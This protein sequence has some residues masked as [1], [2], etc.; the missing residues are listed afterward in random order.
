MEL[1]PGRDVVWVEGTI[2]SVE[3]AGS[4]LTIYVV[5][6]EGDRHVMAGDW[7]PVSLI[8]DEVI[9]RSR[10]LGINPSDLVVQVCAHSL[11]MRKVTNSVSIRIGPS[12]RPPYTN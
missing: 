12:P 10:A 9:S 8:L 1:K 4:L 5:D 6:D 11:P 2:Q 7:R 3:I